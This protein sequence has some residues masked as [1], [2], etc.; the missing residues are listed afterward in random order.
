MN[1]FLTGATG[2]VGAAVAKELLAA[3]VEVM[4]L[5]RTEDKARAVRERGMVPIVGT[6]EELHRHGETV[7]RADAVVHT[8]F[9]DARGEDTDVRA[10]RAL[11]AA[12]PRAFVYASSAYNRSPWRFALEG[13]VVAAGH[14]RLATSV[15]RLGM[16]YGGLGGT[17]PDLFAAAE[18]HGT[19]FYMG[20][21]RARVSAIH[22]DDAASLFHAIVRHQGRG[23]FEGVDGQ[24]LTAR[25]LAEAIAGAVG[26][27]GIASGA[28]AEFREHTC[29]VLER[30][31]AVLQTRGA[32]VGWHP[33]FP[34]VPAGIRHAYEEWKREVIGVG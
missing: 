20:E 12:A 3:R 19:S 28:P 17:M 33:R 5:V 22:R 34:N 11:L 21:G 18:A 1:V 8:A 13:E 14:E 32:S 29:D 6:L 24:P 31:V 15:V 2:Y 4:A 7:R 30:D 10:T 26:C 16:V 27:R 23:I 25:A 9:D